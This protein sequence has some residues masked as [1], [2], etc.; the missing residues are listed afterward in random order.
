MAEV[1]LGHVARKE[2]KLEVFNSVY[3]AVIRLRPEAPLRCIFPCMLRRNAHKFIQKFK[4]HALYAVKSNPDPYILSVLYASGINRFD[5]ASLPEIELLSSLCPNAQLSFMHPVKSRRAIREAYFLHGI[6]EFVIDTPDELKK[7]WEETSF[8]KD[9]TIIV[10]LAM[11]KGSALC[12][13]AGKFGI[14][15][16][17]AP[18]LLKQAKEIASKTGISFHI[19]S[20]SL[21]PGSYAKAIQMAGK[22]IK[23][24]GDK[25]DVFDVGGG[26]PIPHLGIE[27]PSLEKFFEEIESSIALLSLPSECEV[28][29]EPGRALSGTGEVLIVKVELRKENKLYINDGSFGNMFEVCS[30]NWKNDVELIRE[31]P[32][33]CA[34]N[35]LLP[36]EFFGPTCDSVDYSKGPFLLP[37]DIHEGDWIAIYGMGAYMSASQSN[38]NGFGFTKRVVIENLH[39]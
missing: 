16:D 35:E 1:M 31:N 21:V 18:I 4:G 33:L 10:R 14:H 30:M 37:S 38:F 36:Y 7:L 34:R 19:G 39:T 8:A 27:P 20:Q 6:R 11:P 12:S 29:A 23:N 15:T 32:L 22:V 25:I 24:Y 9:L 28:W 13:L 17:K 26:F 5:V 3:E 2:A